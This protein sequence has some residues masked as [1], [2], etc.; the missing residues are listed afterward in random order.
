MRYPATVHR[1]QALEHL[2]TGWPAATNERVERRTLL[3]V[4]ESPASD[5]TALA[6]AQTEVLNRFAACP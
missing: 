3:A 2:L 1:Q 5:G 4:A 6:H